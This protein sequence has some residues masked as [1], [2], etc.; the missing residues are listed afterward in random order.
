MEK[1]RFINVFRFNK[2]F[3]IVFCVLVIANLIFYFT[4]GT[5]QKDKLNN[6]QELYRAKR[7]IKP[8]GENTN[9]QKLLDAKKDIQ[10]FVGQLSPRTEFPNVIAELIQII[11]KHG[12]IVSKMTYTPEPVSFHNLLKFTTAFSVI[13]RYQPVKTFLADLQE[14]KTLFCIDD[15]SIVNKSTQEEESIE[16]KLQI[17]TFFK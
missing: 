4:V 3:W 14:S 17:S 5:Y 8:P 13:G 10:F 16:L 6:L 12:L 2:F 11:H 9:Q 7:M 15:F 1:N